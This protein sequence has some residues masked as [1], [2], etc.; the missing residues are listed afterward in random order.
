VSDVEETDEPK[1]QP[2]EMTAETGSER[3]DED[4]TSI[5]AEAEAT[6]DPSPDCMTH[7]TTRTEATDCS[8]Q[9]LALTA[10]P[11]DD[12]ERT[13]EAA[14]AEPGTPETVVE[15]DASPDSIVAESP[16]SLTAPERSEPANAEAA[17]DQMSELALPESLLADVLTDALEDEQPLGENSELGEAVF[18]AGAFAVVFSKPLSRLTGSDGSPLAAE[19]ASSA[20]PILYAR[21]KRN[22]SRNSPARTKD[23]PDDIDDPDDDS[24][25]SRGQSLDRDASKFD[26]QILASVAEQYESIEAAIDA[27]L[28]GWS[29]SSDDSPRSSGIFHS[30]KSFAAGALAA[31]TALLTLQGSRRAERSRPQVRPAAATYH[32]QTAVAAN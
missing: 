31:A 13:Q 30:A 7:G 16:L 24:Q 23:K 6:S 12:S 18:A 19:S 29:D 20:I 3:A 8:T 2:A 25:P 32:G 28:C 27:T 11:A 26:G 1:T 9:Q 5:D 10:Q 21:K 4:S 22:V 15:Q 17:T 14:T